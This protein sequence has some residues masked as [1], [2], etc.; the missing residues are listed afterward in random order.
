MYKEILLYSKFS[1]FAFQWV[2][3]T[4]LSGQVYVYSHIAN[5]FYY[6]FIITYHFEFLFFWSPLR[7]CL[8]FTVDPW[9]GLT[10]H[11]IWYPGHTV[12]GFEHMWREETPWLTVT[13]QP[14]SPLTVGFVCWT[15]MLLLFKRLGI[16]MFKN[17]F[18][19]S[20]PFRI[21]MVQIWP[22]LWV[23]IPQ[24]LLPWL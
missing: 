19:D 21:C 23:S 15:Q 6:I 16:K 1:C 8:W 7:F 11:V 22:P 5:R 18:F 3:E 9:T 20:E 12:H 4:M 13:L 17:N 2:R 10:S 24:A 14:E